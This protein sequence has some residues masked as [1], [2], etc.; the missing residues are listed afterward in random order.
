MA[1]LVRAPRHARAAFLCTTLLA[2]FLNR[3]DICPLFVFPAPSP[4]FLGLTT[5]LTLHPSH[6]RSLRLVRPFLFFF[7]FFLASHHYLS[8]LQCVCVCA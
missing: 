8:R 6:V 3:D 2:A 1:S 7:N 4:G 5:P